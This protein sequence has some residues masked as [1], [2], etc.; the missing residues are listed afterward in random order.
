M[1]YEL[2]ERP[3]WRWWVTPK[4]LEDKAIHRWYVFPHSF[5]SE[6]VHALSEEWGLGSKDHILDPFVGAGTTILAAKEKGVPAS[7]YDLSPLAVSIARAKIEDYSVPRLE[8][9]WQVLKWH[10]DPARWNGASRTYPNLVCKALP[11]RLLGAFDAIA[12]RIDCLPYS[13]AEQDFFRLAL[14]ASLPHYSRAVATGGWLKW[15]DRRTSVK[16]LPS[17]L[18]RRVEDMLADLRLARLPSGAHWRVELADARQLPDHD[19][20]YSAVITSP[21]Y[22]NRHDYTRVFGVELMFGFFNWEETRKLRYQS[23]HSHPEARPERP[24]ANGYVQPKALTRVIRRLKEKGSDRRILRMLEGYFLDM[25]LCLREVKRVCH[26]DARIAFVV[27]NAQ[28]CGEPIFVD[29]LT[30]EAGEQ[31]GLTCEKL[32]VT[33]YRGNSAQQMGKYR[34]NPSRES[35]VIFRKLKSASTS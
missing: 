29:E 35:L 9:A 34:R 28:Y 2:E 6:L 5:T 15:V 20:T 13:A 32:L 31:A 16:S 12:R 17:V 19:S 7:G 10:L 14:F 24:Q 27:G 4:P 23:F 18:T 1:N 11:G 22:P 8:K 33:R 3:T 26:R 25:Y 21:P 30:A